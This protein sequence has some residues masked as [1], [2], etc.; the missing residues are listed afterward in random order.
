MSKAVT[1]EE[2]EAIVAAEKLD[3]RLIS[4]N[5]AVS[6]LSQV[7]L[8]ERE[9]TDTRHGKRLRIETGEFAV[10]Q[11]V[12]MIDAAENLIAIGLHL[13][14]EKSVQPKLVLL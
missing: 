2:L 13:K 10:N 7:V 14:W 9:I 5:E 3:D 11:T 8:S 1:L 4:M 6:H 12:R